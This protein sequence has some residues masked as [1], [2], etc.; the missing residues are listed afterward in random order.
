MDSLSIDQI[1]NAH[2]TFS[3]NNLVKPREKHVKDSKITILLGD[4]NIAKYISDYQAFL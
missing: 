1:K 3:K 4:T 2:D